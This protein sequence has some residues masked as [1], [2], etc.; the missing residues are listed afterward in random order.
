MMRT[1]RF[2]AP[3]AVRRRYRAAGTWIGEAWGY[4]W[5]GAVAGGAGS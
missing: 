3:G 1:G 2:L 4:P 5:S